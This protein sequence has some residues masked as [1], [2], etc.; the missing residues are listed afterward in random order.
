MQIK[1][2]QFNEKNTNILI[3][4][5]QSCICKKNVLFLII[6]SYLFL[7]QSGLEE[8][9]KLSSVFDEFQGTLFAQSSINFERAV[10][11]ITLNKQLDAEITKFLLLS[12]PYFL[13]NACH[14]ALEWLVF[15]YHIHHY[16][17][18]QFILLILPYHETRIFVRYVLDS[19]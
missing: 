16:N 14:K 6:L 1:K 17:K 7:G 15:R 4:F 5:C 11:N 12:T 10:Q 18:E 3:F 19:Y 13:L 9:Q 8:L 2:F